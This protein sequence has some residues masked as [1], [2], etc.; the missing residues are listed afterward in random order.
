MGI[1]DFFKCFENFDMRVDVKNNRN[2]NN[3]CIRG[4]VDYEEC[5]DSYDVIDSLK[6]RFIAFDVETTGLNSNEDRI[7]EIGAVLF[8]NGVPVRKFSTLINAN[9]LNSR[10]AMRVNKISNEMLRKSPTESVVYPKL[11]EFLGDSLCGDTIICAHNAKFDMKFLAN[12]LE[13][14]G[15]S[16]Y[17]RYFDTLRLSRKLIYG[18]V[19]YRQDTIARHLNIRNVE[20]HRAASDAETCGKILCCIIDMFFY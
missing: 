6:R 5:F 20:T 1:I 18:L 14:L 19:N 12:T 8:E 17:I 9:K 15:Y 11:L 2:S 7:I 10:E 13:R 3:T 4:K 16:A